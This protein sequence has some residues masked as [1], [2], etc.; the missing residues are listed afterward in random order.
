MIVN[1]R[2]Q[3]I[4]DRQAALRVL[5]ADKINLRAIKDCVDLQIL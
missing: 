2:I 1:K 5:E 4:T 3:I